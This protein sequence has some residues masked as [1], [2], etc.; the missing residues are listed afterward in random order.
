M[1]AFITIA[2]QLSSVIYDVIGTVKDAPEDI[3]RLAGKVTTLET[4]LR[5]ISDEDA[6]N[7]D[8][9]DE[10]VSLWA[11]K[12]QEL[13]ADFA[14]YQDMSRELSTLLEKDRVSRAKTKCLWFFKKRDVEALNKKL[15]SHINTFMIIVKF[16][17]LYVT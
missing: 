13:E 12:L 16:L 14:E 4:I 10:F 15:D 11:E 6:A 3:K 1:L 7:P 9:K 2:A 5:R 17:T 8:R